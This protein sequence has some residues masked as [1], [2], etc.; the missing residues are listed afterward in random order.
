M[1]VHKGDEILP[2]K[3]MV[4]TIAFDFVAGELRSQAN[5]INPIGFIVTSYHV[6]KEAV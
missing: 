6:D 4:A 2:P 1:I 5:N 3:Q